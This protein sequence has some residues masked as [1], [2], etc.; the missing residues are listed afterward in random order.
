MHNNEMAIYPVK[1]K[2]IVLFVLSVLFVVIGLLFV[3]K[4]IYNVNSVSSIVITMVILIL[5]HLIDSRK[6]RKSNAEAYAKIFSPKNVLAPI[7]FMSLVIILEIIDQTRIINR[8]LL[9]TI[10]ILHFGLSAIYFLYRLVLSKP[11][12]IINDKGLNDNSSLL[13]AGEITWEEI[14]EITM[15]SYMGNRFV[16]ITVNEDKAKRLNKIKRMLLK[17][18]N[19][20]SISEKSVSIP[21]TELYDILNEL[22]QRQIQAKDDSDDTRSGNAASETGINRRV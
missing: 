14:D 12:L 19:V 6:L 1:W 3:T 5:L 7:A 9:G 4:A 17:A 11:S 15:Y 20:I 18:R 21:L 22:W 2:L 10:S 13:S 8:Y 16:G